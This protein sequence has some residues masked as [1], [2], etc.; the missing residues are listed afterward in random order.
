RHAAR[1]H[2]ARHGFEIF[3]AH[4]VLHHAH[5]FAHA[6]FFHA[7]HH[8]L[9]LF[10]LFGDAVHILHLRAGAGGD[11]FAARGVEQ[12]G[13]GAFIGR[14]G[15]DDG[16]L[17]LEDL[18]VHARFFQLVGHFAQAREHFHQA[19][20]AAHF[21]D[22]LHLGEQIVKIEFAFAEFFGHFLGLFAVD[23]LYGLFD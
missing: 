18:V 12:L 21:P 10:L 14:H 23:D 9:H 7:L 13:M 19:A 4:D 5:H 20:G 22:L 17:T 1:A 16:F 3:A 8:D 15:L 6:H 11:A 2:A